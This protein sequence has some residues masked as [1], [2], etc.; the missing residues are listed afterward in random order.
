MF[1]LH[2]GLQLLEV[3]WVNKE[4]EDAFRPLSENDLKKGWKVLQED[5]HYHTKNVRS[6]VSKVPIAYLMCDRLIL[7]PEDD[8]NKDE[9]AD[10]DQKLIA[11]H[12]I[13]QA[14]HAAVAEEFLENSGPRKKCPQVNGDNTVFLH[15]SKSVFGKTSW[16]TNARSA[17]RNKDGRLA[18]LLL[19]HNL[20]G[21]NAMDELNANNKSGILLLRYDG[22]T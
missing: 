10:F 6:A 19:S 1:D 13:I 20:E 3:Q 17:E 7:F 2:E 9:Y 4:W 16:W 18:N 11:C 22:D 5:F 14:V 12:L 15:F 8:D 21:C